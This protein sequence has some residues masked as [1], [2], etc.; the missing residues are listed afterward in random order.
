MTVDASRQLQFE[1][2][3]KAQSRF[4]F[5]VAYGVVRNPDDAEDVVQETFLKLYRN[6]AWVD[7]RDE[8]AFLARTA[9]RIAVDK[10]PIRHA[11]EFDV[12]TSA[13]G[14]EE[15]AIATDW[16][17]AVHRMLDALPQEFR[18]VLVL[19]GIEGLNSREMATVIGIPEGT[20]R[21]RLMRAR[22]MMKQ[23]IASL[24]GGHCAKQR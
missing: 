21:T 6:G 19:S 8:R 4:V 2:L 3:V 10:R 11:P 7:M 20:V 15:E 22:E 13:A 1:A 23:R 18:Q 12:A 5:R 17:A 14:P 9:W 24:Q 16:K